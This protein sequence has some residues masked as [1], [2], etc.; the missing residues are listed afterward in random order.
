MPCGGGAVEGGIAGV[1][2]A[3]AD[4]SLPSALPSHPASCTSSQQPHPGPLHLFPLKFTL[5]HT[6]P[7]SPNPAWVLPPVCAHFREAQVMLLVG[8]LIILTH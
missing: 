3:V 4:E 5:C 6:L 7:E 1:S 8:F 2:A